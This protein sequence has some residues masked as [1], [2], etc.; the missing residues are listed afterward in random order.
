MSKTLCMPRVYLFF[1]ALI[2]CFETEAQDPRWNQIN[3]TGRITQLSLPDSAEFQAG[4]LPVEI[5]SDDSLT[6]VIY[7][8]NRGRYSFSL[9][10]FHR[11]QIRYGGSDYVQKTVEIDATDFSQGTM[12]RGYTLDIDMALFKSDPKHPISIAG[13]VARAAYDKKSDAVL[14]DAAHTEKVRKATLQ[15]IAANYTEN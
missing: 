12:T 15:A 7:A 8:D 6:T 3:M 14:W 4:G 10:F 1:T 9:P 2:F 11:Y 13:P 5:W